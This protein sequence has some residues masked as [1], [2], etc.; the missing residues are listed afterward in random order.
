MPSRPTLLT[1]FISSFRKIEG[2]PQLIKKRKWRRLRQLLNSS[3]DH[4]DVLSPFPEY[5]N[6]QNPLHALCRENPPID[7]VKKFIEASPLSPI[8]VDD[9]KQT[10]LHMA[11]YSLASA[12]VI[13]LLSTLYPDTASTKDVDGKTPLM[14]ACDK[15]QVNPNI[16]DNIIWAELDS[17]I[18]S[19]ESIK[20]LIKASPRTVA[21]EDDSGQ[22]ALE[23]AISSEAPP[24]IIR[25][26][27]HACSVECLRKRAETRRKACRRSSGN[28]LRKSV[29]TNSMLEK[30]PLASRLKRYEIPLVID[31]TKGSF[32]SRMSTL[33]F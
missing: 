28:K 20:A 22:S 23:Y 13:E 26:L 21:D 1:T 7:L 6:G 29:S 17:S 16:V 9:Q 30:D 11:A 12:D 33:S 31:T 25:V 32:Q 27:Q 3:D 4:S 10:P 24:C 5:G 18:W 19:P 8:E 14:L 15:S 2:V